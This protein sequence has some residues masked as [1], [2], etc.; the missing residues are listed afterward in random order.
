[1]PWDLISKKRVSITVA[2]WDLISCKE[3]KDLCTYTHLGLCGT[4]LPCIILDYGLFFFSNGNDFLF[5]LAK[6]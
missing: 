3:G 1:M 5:C 2:L 6:L 4:K